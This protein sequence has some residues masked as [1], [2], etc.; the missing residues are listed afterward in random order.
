MTLSLINILIVLLVSQQVTELRR[1]GAIFYLDA[2]Y[3]TAKGNIAVGDSLMHAQTGHDRTRAGRR[4]AVTTVEDETMADD[5]LVGSTITGS[6][7][8][9]PQLGTIEITHGSETINDKVTPGQLVSDTTDN[10][11]GWVRTDGTFSVELNTTPTS[12][13]LVTANYCY[14]YDTADDGEPLVPQVNIQ[15]R[16]ETLTAQDFPLRASYAVGAS[17]DLEKAHG[18]ELAPLH[19]N[20]YRKAA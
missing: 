15:L 11:C 18:S 7:A 13:G 6:L 8:Y 1:Q 3:G 19:S 10:V 17:I 5:T 9:N 2:L 16:A 14:Y 4:Y 20:M 12:G